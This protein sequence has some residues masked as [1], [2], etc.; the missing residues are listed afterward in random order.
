M[1]VSMTFQSY[2]QYAQRVLL[3]TSPFYRP[4]DSPTMDVVGSTFAWSM[5]RIGRV[6][7]GSA[8]TVGSLGAPHARMDVDVVMVHVDVDIVVDGTRGQYQLMNNGLTVRICPYYYYDN[9]FAH[10]QLERLS[11]ALGRCV[12]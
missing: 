12:P 10:P 7:C 5:L 4:C 9:K 2:G 6:G 11:R 3:F 1:S 8:G